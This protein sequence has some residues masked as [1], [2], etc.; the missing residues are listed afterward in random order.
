[1]LSDRHCQLLTAYVDGELDE[2][3]RRSVLRLVLESAEARA[4]LERL[5]SDSKELR[6][7]PVHKAPDTL[8]EVVMD[9]LTDV[10]RPHLR[11]AAAHA[12]ATVPAWLGLVAAACM[13]FA[14]GLGTFLFFSIMLGERPEE[15]EASKS[16]PTAPP[17]VAP[18][19]D[20]LERL[21]APSEVAE[22]KELDPLLGDLFAGAAEKFGARVEPKESYVS[23]AV[24]QL[25][26][27]PVRDRLHKALKKDAAV[28]M[29]LPVASSARAIDRLREA[30][31]KNGIT[32]LVD[33]GARNT[34]NPKTQ[35]K[36]VSYVLYV[37][38][39]R[40]EE[41]TQVLQAV[42]KAEGTAARTIDVLAIKGLT[43]ADRTDLSKL[44][45]VSAKALEPAKR[46]M[47]L[48][49][50]IEA[51]PK[52][53]A[54]NPNPGTEPKVE[55]FALVLAKGEGL[56]LNPATSKE[57]K[58]FMDARKDGVDP[59]MLQ[60]AVFIHEAQV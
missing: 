2:R 46:I 8:A 41:L 40:P 9:T 12:S 54:K 31:K 52:K 15:R 24:G 18:G 43:S 22:V 49:P 36:G 5:E 55:R 27:A 57:I 28:H 48:P 30:F 26:D 17:L 35:T 51:D 45:N 13:L 33:A 1:M 32:V 25:Q 56:K 23:V 19:R 4:F 7:L 21:P 10:P 29:D 6:G 39:V 11:P 20:P 50:L 44:L 53:A 16:L 14:V 34:L 58:Q 47:D 38:N 42:G 59:R 60:V 37:E 3:Q